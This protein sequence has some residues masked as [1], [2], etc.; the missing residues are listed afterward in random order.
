P[1]GISSLITGGAEAGKWLSEDPR[2][3][4]ISATGS[5]NM[6]KQV[7]TT[8]A[9]RVGKSLL[10]LGGNDAIIV[11]QDVNLEMK[12]IGAVFGAVGNA[13][14]R[15]TSTRR[16]IVHENIYEEVKKRLTKAYKQ[17]NIGDPLNEEN[18]IGPLID[19]HAVETYSQALL[20]IQK[21]GGKI[22]TDAGPLEGE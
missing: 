4:L 18:H 13:G 1:E 3:P 5:T 15:C 9:S 14:Q 10:E 11:T 21:Q 2:I 22:I 12:L 7:A 8:V 16:L 20:E 6:G 17:L 19:K